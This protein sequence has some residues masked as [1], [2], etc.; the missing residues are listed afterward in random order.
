MKSGNFWRNITMSMLNLRD[1][2]VLYIILPCYGSLSHISH[3]Q[4]RG[5]EILGNPHTQAH[6]HTPSQKAL[7]GVPKAPPPAESPTPLPSVLEPGTGESAWKG[8]FLVPWMAA[9][10]VSFAALFLISSSFSSCS[11]SDKH[12]KHELLHHNKTLE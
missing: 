11:Y 10:A 2:E 3:S 12:H 1:F 5:T 7:T 9:K 8:L 4:K 6:V